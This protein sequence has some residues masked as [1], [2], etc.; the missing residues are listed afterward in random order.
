M[1]TLTRMATA[2]AALLAAGALQAQVVAPGV[3]AAAATGKPA[4]APSASVRAAQAAPNPSG[5][6][7]PFPAG[8]TSGSGAA[9]ARD[10]VAAWNAVTA[11][12]VGTLTPGAGNGVGADFDFPNGPVSNP[13]VDP[14]P[15]TANPLA[16]PNTAVL[17]AGPLVARGP[18]ETVPLGGSGVDPVA[19]ARGFLGADRNS[20]GELTRAEWLVLGSP[21]GFE[22]VDRNFDGVV[23]R[24]EYEDLF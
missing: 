22:E 12:Q 14:G 21:L 2:V 6:T 7:A 3:R 19:V 17:G 15:D 8:V 16:P 9:V 10:P 23:T 20:N 5:L 24:F 1:S 18:A 4:G 13:G 11:G